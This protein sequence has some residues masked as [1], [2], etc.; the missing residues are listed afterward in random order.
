M[1]LYEPRGKPNL[2]QK[3]IQL[4]TD[5]PYTHAAIYFDG[6]MYEED[7]DGVGAKKSPGDYS[8]MLEPV[9][10][11]DGSE[12][13]RMAAYLDLAYALR[14]QYNIRKLVLLAVVYPLRQLFSQ[15]GWTPFDSWIYGEV[16]SGFAAE[17]WRATLR[18]DTE[19]WYAPGDLMNLDG[20]TVKHKEA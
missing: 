19:G 20:F 12:R 1:F 4:I 8:V 17:A 7:V 10:S 15:L 2:A 6:W 14:W 13:R 11:L 9:E 3:L 5:S 18:F 16:C